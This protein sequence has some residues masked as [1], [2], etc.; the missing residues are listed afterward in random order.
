MLHCDDKQLDNALAKGFV[1]FF[2][3]HN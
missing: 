3:Q 2:I 1:V